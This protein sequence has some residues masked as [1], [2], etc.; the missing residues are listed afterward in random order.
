MGGGFLRA[1]ALPFASQRGEFKE[2]N[3]TAELEVCGIAA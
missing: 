3:A 2:F 1:I